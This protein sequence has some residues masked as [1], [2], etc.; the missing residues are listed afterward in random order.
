MSIFIKKYKLSIPH[1][2]DT[3]DEIWAQF[4]LWCQRRCCLKVL[5]MTGYD[6]DNNGEL[7]YK[8]FLSFLLCYAKDKWMILMLNCLWIVINENERASFVHGFMNYNIKVKNRHS[9]DYDQ[10]KEI[11]LKTYNGV[12][13]FFVFFCFVFCFINKGWML[14][15]TQCLGK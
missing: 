13:V 5:T 4:A 9:T 8:A 12:V 15:V 6:G 2:K 11:V 3:T 1:P 7:S 10:K 14:N